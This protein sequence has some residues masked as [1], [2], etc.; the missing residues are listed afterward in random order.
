MKRNKS[1]S[2]GEWD[3]KKGDAH[4][5][6]KTRVKYEFIEAHQDEHTVVKMCE[7]LGVSTSGYYKW[8]ER[9]TQEE[10]EKEKKRNELKRKISKSFHESLGTYGSPRVH[11]DLIDWG[12]NVFQKTV[13]RYMQ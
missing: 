4:L 2:R 5:H 3:F 7:V 8:K 9:Q 10:T 12:Y 1:S 6:E 11:D 13:A